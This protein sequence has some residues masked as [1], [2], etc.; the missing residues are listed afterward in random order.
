MSQSP[1]QSFRGK[2]VLQE[3]GGIT[4]ADGFVDGGEK[5]GK[6]LG[7]EESCNELIVG[8]FVTYTG[9][10]DGELEGLLVVTIE[11]LPEGAAD[12]S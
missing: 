3:I 2:S 7:L 4:S 11:S 10:L 9:L 12:A 1:S 6:R 5:E 8:E